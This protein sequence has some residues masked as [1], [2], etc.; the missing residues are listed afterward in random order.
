MACDFRWLD[1]NGGAQS[2]IELKNFMDAPVISGDWKLG[3]VI[4][5]G[6]PVTNNSLIA[7]TLNAKLGQ[8]LLIPLTEW[9]GVGYQVCGFANVRLLGYELASNPIQ[10]TVQFLH[11]LVRSGDS[12][13]N[14]NDYGVRDVRMLD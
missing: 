3:D 9:N 6:M 14:A 12:D 2:T 4:P 8:D 5:P 7:A 10:M 1:W 13:P 11:E